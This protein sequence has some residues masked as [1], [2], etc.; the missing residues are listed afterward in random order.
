MEAV[1]LLLDKRAD[2]TVKNT[3]DAAPLDLAIDNMHSEVAKIMLR[4]KR[5][6]HKHALRGVVTSLYSGI[7]DFT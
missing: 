1:E 2:V 3:H 5:Y 7:A 6:N 4:S